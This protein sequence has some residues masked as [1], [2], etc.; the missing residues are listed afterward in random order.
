VSSV[1]RY[2][3]DVLRSEDALFFTA[4]W[5]VNSKCSASQIDDFSNVSTSL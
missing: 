1:M 3:S 2:V 4:R 5:E